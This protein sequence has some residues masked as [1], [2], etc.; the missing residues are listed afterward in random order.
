MF[1]MNFTSQARALWAQINQKTGHVPQILWDSI[2]SFVEARATE[3]ASS[4][5]YYAL[6][7]IFPLLIF[8]IGFASSFLED[9]A[10]QQLIFNF[11]EE[12]LPEFF[13]DL[14]KG[15]I[16]Q[17][18]ALRGSVQIVGMIG[19]LWGASAVF[20]I[21]THNIDRAWHIAEER[22]FI[23]GRL[24]GLGMIG[25]IT[26][27]LV[28]LWLV[29]TTMFNILPALEIPLQNGQSI[30]LY[31]SYTWRWLA[32]FLPLFLIFF[33]FVNLY[34]WTPNTTVKWR[35]AVGGAAVSALGWE[36]AQR[37]FSWYLTSG[38]ARY[39]L[40]YGSLGAVIAFLLWLYVN[41]LIVLFGAH[42]S[43][44]IASHTRPIKK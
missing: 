30:P 26:A 6:F 33:T 29:S 5:A 41:A 19:L 10:I 12:T 37:G 4:I 44:A 15:N 35:E 36:L 25:A 11:V 28:V 17:A 13:Q 18:L 42:L 40:V 38:W 7:S 16:E 3:A 8:V 22:N 24:A 39:Q 32:Q 27:G 1:G 20:T 23:F 14:I 43:A 31:D 34:K 2:Q 9:S 21:I